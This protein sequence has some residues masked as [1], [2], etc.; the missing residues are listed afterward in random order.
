MISREKFE[1]LAEEI[2]KNLQEKYKDKIYNLAVLVED[3]P[4]EEQ[5]KKVGAKSKYSL[6]GL[7]EGRVQSRHVNMGA[8]LPDK[9]S[10]FY[11]V[12]AQ[13]CADEEECKKRIENTL[14]HEI[15]H[16]FGSDERGARKAAKTR[17]HYLLTK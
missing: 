12:I 14:K 5:L 3:F 6:L 13:S 1:K 16:H 8:V 9:I 4:T 7:Y 2:Y 10:L 17:D 11:M 15:A